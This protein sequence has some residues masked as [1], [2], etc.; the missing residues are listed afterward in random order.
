VQARS[1]P[2]WAVRLLATSALV[3]VLIGV[4]DMV[5]L[6]GQ[7]PSTFRTVGLWA[8]GVSIIAALLVCGIAVYAARTGPVELEHERP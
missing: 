6:T 4:I 1:T 5:R 7:R 3:F 2:R 8:C